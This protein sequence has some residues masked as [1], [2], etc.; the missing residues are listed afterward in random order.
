MNLRKRLLPTVLAAA[1]LAGAAQGQSRISTTS[2]GIAFGIVGSGSVVLDISD[3]EGTMGLNGITVEIGDGGVSV[4]GERVSDAPERDV[5]LEDDGSGV[6]LAVDGVVVWPERE[7]ESDLARTRL[8]E[9]EEALAAGDGEAA[10]RLAQEAM[11]LGDIDAPAFMGEMLFNGDG[12]PRN[13]LKARIMFRQA[14]ARGDSDGA[15]FLGFMHHLGQGARL[16]YQEAARY[17]REAAGMGN[18][19]A[20]R[21][22]PI[23]AAESDF[24]AVSY[25]EALDWLE[26]LETLGN[27]D[28]GVIREKVENARGG[29]F[30]DDEPIADTPE[31]PDEDDGDDA[32]RAEVQDDE[33]SRTNGRR[34][35][36][37]GDSSKR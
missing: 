4:R 20:I 3:G 34:T 6:R 31:F 22:L 30:E 16:D 18:E 24:A 12:V 25:D 35:G 10:L 8:D 19:G 2:E 21:N 11:D 5:L 13:L 23:L 15:L 27:A 36:R 28:V 1:L 32:D 17:Y 26:E 37:R 14:A 7:D 9:A 29:T 33:P